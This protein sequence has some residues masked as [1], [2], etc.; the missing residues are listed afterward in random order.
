MAIINGPPVPLSKILRTSL[1]LAH[2]VAS[3]NKIDFDN[4]I[5]KNESLTG[6]RTKLIKC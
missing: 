1:T 4:L 5:D 2:G 6:F 3:H